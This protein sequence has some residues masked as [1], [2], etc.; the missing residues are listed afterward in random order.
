M[1][2]MTGGP[3]AVPGTEPVTVLVVED[4]PQ[5]L[6]NVVKLLSAFP[7]VK[8]IGTAMDGETGLVEAAKLKPNVVLLDDANE[9]KHAG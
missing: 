1:T 6:K 5:L 2:G 7:A 9:I 8:V 3:G 4:Q